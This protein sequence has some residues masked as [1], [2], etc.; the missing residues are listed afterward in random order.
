[1]TFFGGVPVASHTDHVGN[2]KS[3]R[4]AEDPIS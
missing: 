3:V 1:M 2:P 4:N